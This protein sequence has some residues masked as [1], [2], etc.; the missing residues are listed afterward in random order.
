MRKILKTT[1]VL[2][3]LLS[4]LTACSSNLQLIGDKQNMQNDINTQIEETT[5]DIVEETQNNT[6]PVLEE[7]QPIHVHKYEENI[8]TSTCIKKGYTAYVCECGDTYNDNY[9]DLIEHT[10]NEKEVIAPTEH[11]NGYTIFVCSMCN[12][13][14]K[15]N[16]VDK[17]P[18]YTPVNET[19]YLTGTNFLNVRTGPGTEYQKIGEL[20]FTSSANRIGIGDNGWSQISYNGNVAYVS[21]NY[22]TTIKREYITLSNTKITPYDYHWLTAEDIAIINQVTDYATKYMNGEVS[23]SYYMHSLGQTEH[24]PNSSRVSAYFMLDFASWNCGRELYSLGVINRSG[25]PPEN[26][27]TI[28]ASNYANL[29]QQRAAMDVE[30]DRVLSTF[31]V[32]TEEELLQQIADYLKDNISY[33]ENCSD[34]AEAIFTGR[35]NC[36]AF[37]QLFMRMAMRLGINCDWCCGV[38]DGG[39][40]HAWNR[41]TFSDGRVR[42]YD[43]CWYNGSENTKYLNSTTCW[44][45]LATVNYEEPQ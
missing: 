1:I 30:I 9:Q 38:A 2:A 28:R 39:G 12:D 43:V 32:G 23:E 44:H 42:Y 16:Y 37:A 5:K 25:E 41:V 33:E 29:L 3:A 15:D 24:S 26:I 45:T 21:S 8:I 13:E 18:Y 19:V 7:T 4:L 40:D 11:E 14:Y 27:I 10:Y 20:S 35:G 6:E 31:V 36:N 34:G 17:L 22:L